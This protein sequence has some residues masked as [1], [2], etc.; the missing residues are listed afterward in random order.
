M[1]ITVR[2]IS[3]LGLVQR[4]C[5]MTM[6]GQKSRVSLAKMY[7]AE[8]SPI[9]CRMFWVE[10][11]GIPSFVSVHLVRHKHGVEHFVQSMRDDLYLKGQGHTV[12]RNTPVNHGMLIN[13]QALIQMSRKRLCFKSHARTVAIWTKLRKAI[14]DIDADLADFMVPECVTRGY[15]PEMTQ[16]RPGLNAVLSAYADAPHIKIRSVKHGST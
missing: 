2:E 14:R 4:A 13:A 8:H 10:M 1:K 16:C 12:D 15:C 9:R 11:Q 7:L 6:H 5:E 3:D